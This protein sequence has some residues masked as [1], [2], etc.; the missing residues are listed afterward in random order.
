M[1]IRVETLSKAGALPSITLDAPGTHG[2]GV[3]GMHGMGV[4]TPNAAAVADAT[5]G[6]DGDMHIPNGMIFVNGM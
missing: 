5:S 6:L 3:T 2:E 1:H 4:S